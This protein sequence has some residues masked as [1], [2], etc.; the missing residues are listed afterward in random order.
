MADWPS[1]AKPSKVTETLVKPKWKAQT[2]AGYFAS[3]GLAT[4]GKRQ[5][6]LEWDVLSTAD[7]NSLQTLFDSNT[8]YSSFTWDE[9]VSGVE[10]DVIFMDDELEFSTVKRSSYWQGQVTLREV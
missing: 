1:I 7:K 5:W 4:T 10:K 9:P 2:E 8:G 6:T 3:R